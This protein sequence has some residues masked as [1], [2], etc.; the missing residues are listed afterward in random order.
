MEAAKRAVSE[1]V[2]LEAAAASR[3]HICRLEANAAV[4]ARQRDRSNNRVRKLLL[5][6]AF[7]SAAPCGSSRLG[8]VLDSFDAE[9]SDLVARNKES[10][11]QVFVLKSDN[12]QKTEEC[13][14]LEGTVAELRERV[15]E[16]RSQ[17]S[18]QQ[19]WGPNP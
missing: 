9:I 14:E 19:R 16:L 13:V 7:S 4:M 10:T 3:R 6:G 1:K 5:S 11:A 18:S 8:E 12:S 15:D 17:L 2:A